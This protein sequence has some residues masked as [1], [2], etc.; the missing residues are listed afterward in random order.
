MTSRAAAPRMAPWAA[1]P[2]MHLRRIGGRPAVRVLHVV[3]TLLHGGTEMAMLRLIRSMDPSAF[4]FRVAW[5]WGEPALGEEVRE[6]TGCPPIPVGLKAKVDPLALLRLCGVVRREAID[7]VHTHMDLADYYGA[8]AARSRP[9]T[10]LVSVKQ[11]ADEFR[12]R[13]TWKRPPFLLLEHAAYAAADAVIA[14]SEGLVDFLERAEG[15]PRH[16]TVVIGNGVDA[17]LLRQAPSRERARLNLG[18]PA[19]APILGSVG[20]LA[21][22]KGQIDLLRALPAIDRAL[23]GTHLVLAGEGPL[24]ARLEDEARSLGVADRLHLLGQR[25]DIPAVLAA[26]D[27][28]VLPSL[29]EGLP[30]ALLEAMAMSLPVVATRAVGVEETVEDGATG[31]LVPMRDPAALAAAASAILGDP[32]LARRM[33]AAGRERAAARHAQPLVAAQVEALYRSVLERRR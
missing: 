18:L 33:G 2:E 5:L 15:L 23:P 9:G 29:W 24:R 21:E 14:V 10:G 22:Q 12:T 32:L 26:L 4:R 3:S 31:F 19:A 27:L 28:F 11:N 25:R 13:R 6:A 7:L 8:A 20:R 1:A 30:M 17:D 16:K